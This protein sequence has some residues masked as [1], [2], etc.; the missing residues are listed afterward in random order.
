MHVLVQNSLVNNIAL[1]F[2]PLK[3]PLQWLGDEEEEGQIS[4]PL[5]GLIHGHLHHFCNDKVYRNTTKLYCLV[6]MCP[7]LVY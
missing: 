3:R 6:E 4:S 5:F 1:K 7:L 2:L